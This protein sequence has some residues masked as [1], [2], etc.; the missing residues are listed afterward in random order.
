MRSAFLT[1]MLFVTIQPVFAQH[2]SASGDHLERRDIAERPPAHVNLL[3]KTEPT[4][5]AYIKIAA[6]DVDGSISPSGTLGLN[7]KEDQHPWF[8]EVTYK[9]PAGPAHNNAFSTLG[10]YQFWTG[11]SDLAPLLQ[12]DVFY[13]NRPGSNETGSVDITGEISRGSLSL[14]AIAAYGWFRPKGGT[15]LNDF[16]PGI[17]V[18]YAVTD[19]NLIGFDYT[20]NNK[21]DGESGFDVAFRHKLPAGYAV[22]IVVF[23]HNDVRLRFRKNFA[24]FRS[25]ATP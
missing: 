17:S 4:T 15:A 11:T 2:E 3:L 13:S 1:I 12:T 19:S 6:I 10:M 9:H 24:A 8:G 20:F 22:D 14:D 25:H 23:K 21:V 16:Q 18:S 7:H 5:N